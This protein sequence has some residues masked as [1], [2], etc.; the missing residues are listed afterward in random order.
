MNNLTSADVSRII[1]VAEYLV[2]LQIK[3]R[4]SQRSY[5]IHILVLYLIILVLA[6][7]SVGIIL[8]YDP[9]IERLMMLVGY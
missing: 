2:R 9:I 5:F 1:D 6:G 8:Y 7:L 4:K 3:Q